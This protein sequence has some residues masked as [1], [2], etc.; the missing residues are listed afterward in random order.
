MT[1][2]QELQSWLEQH[3]QLDDEAAREQFFQ[4]LL[5]TLG[6]KDSDSLREGLLALKES[7]RASRIKAE[8]MIRGK[9]IVSLQVF[10]K[11]HEEQELLQK[12]LERMAI[13]FKMST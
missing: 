4:N 13:P 6:E 8:K 11:S 7:V 2:Q 9:P 5:A 12:L 1:A 3:R 10:P